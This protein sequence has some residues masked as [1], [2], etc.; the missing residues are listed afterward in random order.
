MTA[1]P[2]HQPKDRSSSNDDNNEDE[3][4]DKL[5]P[6]HEGQ[7]DKELSARTLQPAPKET[8]TP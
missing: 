2:T 6:Q 3:D 4:D 1:T 5:R 7:H 8:S